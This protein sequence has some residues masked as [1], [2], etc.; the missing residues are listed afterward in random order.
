MS[1][2]FAASVR[3]LSLLSTLLIATCAADAAE[4]KPLRELKIH[5]AQANN[6]SNYAFVRAKFEP[7]ELADPYAVRF[8]DDR[9]QEVPYF[10]WDSITWKVAREGRDDWG[11]QYALINH[12]PGNSAYNTL[13]RAAKIELA[14]KNWPELGKKLEAEDQAAL[15]NPDSQCAVMYLLRHSVP[16]MGKERLTLRVF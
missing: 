14:K 3:I 4:P 7:G 2:Q 11:H 15:K 5:L 12:A 13:A 10:V 6:Q 9:G 16:A 1:C 8:V